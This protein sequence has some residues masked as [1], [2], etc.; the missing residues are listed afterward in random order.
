MGALRL[1]VLSAAI[2]HEL[3]PKPSLDAEVPARDVVVQRRG[4]LD[5]L[6]LLDAQLKRAPDPAVR[7]DGVRLGLH[8][9]VPGTSFPHVV[10]A[11][12]HERA[13]GADA[14]AVAAVDAGG[15][16]QGAG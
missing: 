12:E 16:C 3:P 14:D 9:L 6:I 5:D 15:V 1:Y 13:G 4:D 11:L 7:A 2:L 8:R 10:L